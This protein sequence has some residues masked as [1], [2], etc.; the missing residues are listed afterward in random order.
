MFYTLVNAT[1]DKPIHRLSQDTFR[2][3]DVNE[4]S[5]YIAQK[6]FNNTKYPSAT[7]KLVLRGASGRTI[8]RK[9]LR[10]RLQH[11]YDNL[12]FAHMIV[13]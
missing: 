8:T 4:V 9:I 5:L 10:Q 13:N 3:K 1:S 6:L 12:K 2:G 11:T 7:V